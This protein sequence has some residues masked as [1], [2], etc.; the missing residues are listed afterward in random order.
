MAERLRS[1]LERA[2]LPTVAPALGAD[3]YLELMARD[4]KVQGGTLRFVLLAALGRAILRSDI[5]LSEVRALV[6]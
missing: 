3:R 6:A 1:L 2:G 5:P 4:K